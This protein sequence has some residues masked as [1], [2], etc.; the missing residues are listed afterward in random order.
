MPLLRKYRGSLAMVFAASFMA[1]MFALGIPL[2][3]Q[4][5]IDKV[6]TQGN[7]SSLNI[8]GAAMLVMALFRGLLQALRNYILVDTTDRMDLTLGS[9]VINRMLGLPIRFFESR[10]VGELSQRFGE[11]NTIRGFL[12]GTTLVTVL[13]VIF[14]VVYIAVMIVYSPAAHSCAAQHPAAVCG[15]D[16][17]L[18][19][20][21]PLVD[22]GA[23][24][25][26]GPHPEPLDRGAQRHPNREGPA[27]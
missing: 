12:T 8:L 24:A 19:A 23:G 13:N 2:L 10:P 27:F 11:L 22:P 5:I 15:Y 4:Q 16:P 9:A 17:H 6:L 7:L 3:L 26:S 1:Q 14:A 25:S 20:D 21:L 18:S